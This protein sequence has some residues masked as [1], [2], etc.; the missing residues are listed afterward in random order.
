VVAF[1]KKEVRT[2]PHSFAKRLHE[3]EEQIRNVLESALLEYS[4]LF[5]FVLLLA[6]VGFGILYYGH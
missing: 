4:V 6:A 5:G 1:A 3:D 2:M